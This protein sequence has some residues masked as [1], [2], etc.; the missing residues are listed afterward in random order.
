M[1]KV[2]WSRVALGQEAHQSCRW[3]RYAAAVRGFHG[4]FA[5]IAGR[6]QEATSAA[7]M[8]SNETQV[9]CCVVLIRT[10]LNRVILIGD[11]PN[12]LKRD[13]APWQTGGHYHDQEPQRSAARS[14]VER[15]Q[16]RRD[17]TVRC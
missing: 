13:E 8:Q 5:S 3:S 10:Q 16:V 9:A 15:P 2:S 4:L 7:A 11:S 14:E 17:C 6:E 12:Y 1:Q